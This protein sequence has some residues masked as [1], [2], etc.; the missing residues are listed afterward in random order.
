M[1][2]TQSIER[3]YSAIRRRWFGELKQLSICELSEDFALQPIHQMWRFVQTKRATDER[4][5]LRI[6]GKIMPRKLN[7]RFDGL[8]W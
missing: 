6:G 2:F 5:L 1:D 4:L 8:K 7:L 3:E